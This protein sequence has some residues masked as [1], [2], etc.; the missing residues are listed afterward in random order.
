MIKLQ[1]LLRHP[2]KEP[3]LDPALRAALEALGMHVDG[4]GRASVS[5]HMAQDDYAT[6]FGQPPLESCELPI[7]AAL[8]D[9]VS[10]I[11]VA[12]HHVATNLTPGTRNAA[13]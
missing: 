12:P 6:L 11:T 10:L 2:G 8:A 7:P 5:A 9:A 3:E 1:L 4:V 13:I